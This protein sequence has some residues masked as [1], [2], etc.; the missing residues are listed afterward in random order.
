MNLTKLLASCFLVLPTSFLCTAFV[1]VGCFPRGGSSALNAQTIAVFGASGR[2]ASECIFQALQDGDQIVGLTRNPSKLTIPV[3][4]GGDKAGQPF[5]D[6]KLTVFAGD[7]TKKEDVD[8][9]FAHADIDSVIVAMGGKTS[10]V[11]ETML[12]D[13]T[14]NIIAAMKEKGVK[15]L[16]VITSIG[17]GDSKSQA[18][19]SFRVL[20]STVLT[21]VFRD[22]NNQEEA[23]MNSGLDY[24]IIRPGSLTLDPPTGIVN[25]IDGK[26]GSIARSD[27]AKFCLDAVRMANFPYLGKAACISSVGGTSWTR[28]GAPNDSNEL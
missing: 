6:S 19:F 14:N 15:R 13:G 24:T 16:A 25:V 8:K 1:L 22:K 3:G 9:V 7:V 2:T 17:A 18:P 21:K 5:A 26:A 12:T 20:M 11:G 28:E 4:S 10:Q 27:V 23:V